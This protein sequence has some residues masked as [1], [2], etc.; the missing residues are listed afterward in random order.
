MA[1]HSEF[2]PYDA[3]LRTEAMK[4]L[5]M[6]EALRAHL[7]LYA[8]TNIL[9][10]LIW[11]LTTPGGFPWP[12]LV[13]AGWGIGVVMNV[14]SVDSRRPFSEAEVQHEIDELRKM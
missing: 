1:A 10:W 5:R 4:R 3:G 2:N 12:A 13:T 8:V 9:L 7:L 11:A 14:W 6:K